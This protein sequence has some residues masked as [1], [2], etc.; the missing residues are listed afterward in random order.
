MGNK[1]SKHNGNNKIKKNIVMIIV[2]ILFVMFVVGVGIKIKSVKQ[3]EMSNDNSTEQTMT[4]EEIKIKKEL[5][6]A[7]KENTY[8]FDHGRLKLE[9]AAE[10]EGPDFETGSMEFGTY[11]ALRIINISDKYLESAELEVKINNDE[12]MKVSIKDVP[13]GAV[14]YC[15]GIGHEGYS[16]T[17]LYKIDKCDSTYSDK[18]FKIPEGLNI[19]CDEWQIKVE[20]NSDIDMTGKTFVY[21]GKMED[22][23]MGG[24]TYTF[25]P[26]TLKPGEVYEAQSE[27]VLGMDIE[28][29]DIK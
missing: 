21:K 24:R 10:Y 16:P 20:N 28:V 26:D 27:S 17:D 6:K 14:V 19:S 8:E 22:M 4:E 29:V 18:E 25:K 15:L 12:N 13:A 11:T 7:E 2:G 5:E 1:M 9:S 3:D 23:L